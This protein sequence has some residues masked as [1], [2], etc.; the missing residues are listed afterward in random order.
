VKNIKSLITT[1]IEELTRVLCSKKTRVQIPGRSNLTQSYKRFATS[2]TSA[3]VAALP[4]RYE[5]KMG[6]VNSLHAS[7]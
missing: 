4:W 6:T 1:M 7:S 3:Q 2:S 5:A